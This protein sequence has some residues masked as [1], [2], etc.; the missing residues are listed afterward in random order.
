MV[1]EDLARKLATYWG[2]TY[3]ELEQVALGI[4]PDPAEERLP[5]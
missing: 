1:G 4:P 5:N 2:M 3:R